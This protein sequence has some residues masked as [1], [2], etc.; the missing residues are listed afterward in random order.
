MMPAYG[1]VHIVSKL[2]IIL[3]YLNWRT[4][5]APYCEGSTDADTHVI[6][7]RLI[8]I[9]ANI[10][11]AKRVWRRSARNGEARIASMEGVNN[12]RVHGESLAND[13]GFVMINDP[14]EP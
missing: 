14:A 12:V 13:C 8:N 4:S 5:A 10:S 2:I 3:E 6:R 7:C 1:D 11:E 9:Y